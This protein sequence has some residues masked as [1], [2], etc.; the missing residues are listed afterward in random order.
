MNE[1][2][3]LSRI[4]NGSRGFR[5][6]V[7]S[8]AN[9][10]SAVDIRAGFPERTSAEGSEDE[11]KNERDI[12]ARGWSWTGVQLCNTNLKRPWRLWRRC[13]RRRRCPVLAVVVVRSVST[14]CAGTGPAS[15]GARTS[16]ERGGFVPRTS[17]FLSLQRGD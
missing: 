11:E 10:A 4:D 6:N 12:W 13:D 7:R 14:A 15:S 2:K 9:A 8:P 16:I 17:L 1:A 5:A 3:M